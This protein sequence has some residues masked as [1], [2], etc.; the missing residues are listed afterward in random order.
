MQPY[1]E[2][3]RS[4]PEADAAGEE[5]IETSPPSAPEANALA[6]ATAEPDRFHRVFFNNEGLRGGWSVILFAILVSLLAPIFGTILS[7]LVFNVAHLSVDP[8]SPLSSIFGEGQ[9]LSAVTAATIVIALLEH[10]RPRDYN[11]GGSHGLR[12]FAGGAV[13]GFAA[14]SALIGILVRGGWMRISQLRLPVR[15]SS[16]TRCCGASPLSWWRCLKRALSAAICN[17]LLRAASTSGGR[18]PWSPL[19]ASTFC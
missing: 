19:S 4:G 6:F 11:L 3:A 17:R 2:P 18:W 9:W 5:R 16:D 12:L 1:Q 13:A 7:I 15:T 8:G 10:R 14:L